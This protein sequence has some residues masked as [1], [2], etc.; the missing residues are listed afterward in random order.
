[1]ELIDAASGTQIWGDRF[2]HDVID[3]AAFQDDVT[4]QIA[5]ALGVELT[6]AKSHRSRQLRPD[7]RDAVDLA[8]QGWSI[9][10][11]PPDRERMHEARRL[12]EGSLSR[13]ACLVS[14][15]VGLALTYVE[16][17]DFWA[18]SR[19]GLRQQS[20]GS[21]QQGVGPGLQ[22]RLCP[23]GQSPDLRFASLVGRASPSAS[24]RLPSSRSSER[25]PPPGAAFVR[26]F[27]A[28]AYG[29]AGHAKEARAAISEFLRMSPDL[30]VGQ[31]EAVQ[32]VMRAQLELAAKGY[33][34]PF[35]W[36]YRTDEPSGAYGVPARTGHP[37]DWR[38]R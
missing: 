22:G 35:R 25:S 20:R 26:V 8:M 23:P 6:D 3:A 9:L 34:G 17:V 37:R 36:A 11:Q 16:E 2:D 4:G 38:L 1:M 18:P 31:P 21:D 5:R 32:T 12:F 7:S 27:L 13:D 33:F 29:R 10:N 24:L 30:M 28:A 14:A 19:R 15:L